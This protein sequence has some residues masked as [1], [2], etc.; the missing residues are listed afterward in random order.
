GRLTRSDGLYSRILAGRPAVGHLL[1]IAFD[2]AGLA[3]FVCILF[4][5]I[6]RLIE[7]W[8]RDYF[9]GNEGLFV[10][11]VWPIRLILVIGCMAVSI[12]FL[13][14]AGGHLRSLL[15]ERA[16]VR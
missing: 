10:V 2:L 6:P 7:A 14:L 16:M 11:P 8:Q 4:G 13:L 1:G 3:F 9:A 12:Q 5:G 15:R